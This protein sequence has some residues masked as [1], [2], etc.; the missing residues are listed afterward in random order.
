M[1][2]QT[3]TWYQKTTLHSVGISLGP[4]R[5]RVASVTPLRPRRVK[6]RLT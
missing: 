5:I 6:T 3:H 4:R 1:P 2:V